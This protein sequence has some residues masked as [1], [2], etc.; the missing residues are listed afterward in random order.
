MPVFCRTASLIAGI[1]L[2]TAMSACSPAP[3]PAPASPSADSTRSFGAQI[4]AFNGELLGSDY[5]EFG[6]ELVFR[7]RDGRITKLLETNVVALHEMPGG[8]VAIT[9]LAHMSSNR[10]AVLSISRSGPHR[11]T[12][13]KIVDLPGAPLVSRQ[14]PDGSIEMKI[15]SGEFSE[16]GDR[17]VHACVRLPA[18]GRL[19]RIECPEDWRDPL[20]W[21]AY[22]PPSLDRGAVA[23]KAP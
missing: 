19:D 13:D 5:G 6:G 11:L 14:R 12:V 8:V 18:T 17:L 16:D 22:S 20:P 9:G 3:D 15:F 7:A 2:C 21:G 1:G 23:A 10:G 4:P